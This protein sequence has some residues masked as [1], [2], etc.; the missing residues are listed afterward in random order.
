MRLEWKDSSFSSS[1]SYAGYELQCGPC[2][3]V[4]LEDSLGHKNQITLDRNALI[5]VGRWIVSVETKPVSI[6][7][8]RSLPAN[9]SIR[10][11]FDVPVETLKAT[12]KL[13][14]PQERNYTKV[15]ALIIKP[16]ECIV[17]ETSTPEGPAKNKPAP[18]RP[19]PDP[20]P[21]EKD[22]EIEKLRNEA[23]EATKVRDLALAELK[24]EQENAQK[25]KDKAQILQGAMTALQ[26]AVTANADTL[27]KELTPYRDQLEADLQKKL[28]ELNELAEKI[29]KCKNTAEEKEREAEEHK[30]EL[31]EWEG[32]AEAKT[33]DCGEAERKLE[34]LKARCGDDDT[35]KALLEEEPFFG[36]LEKNSISKTMERI[37]KELEAVEKRL[38]LILTI[39]EK[40]N[41]KV[42]ETILL[43][44][45]G[46]ISLAEEMGG[47]VNGDGSGPEKADT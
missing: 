9:D 14:P 5:K 12:L 19:D 4:T 40:I 29:Q 35:V 45:D 37:Q 32:I 1:S 13:D 17:V 7:L 31:V 27:I 43:G 28:D 30:T 23:A 46:Q 15:R 34:E 33:L 10:V 21:S 39:R 18:P 42:Q 20:S 25:E 8:R 38:G 24:K 44:S 36:S 3:G 2:A 11:S 41:V 6:G 22:R 47:N 16:N 26:S